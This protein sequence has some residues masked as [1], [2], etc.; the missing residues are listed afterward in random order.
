MYR[1]L[2]TIHR[3]CTRA[4]AMRSLASTSH[5]RLAHAA[6]STRDPWLARAHQP[7]LSRVSLLAT[8]RRSMFIQTKDVPNHNS[9]MFYPNVTVLETGTRDF[10]SGSE[11][12]GS[13]LARR[14]FRI[15]GVSS[16]FFGPDYVTVVKDE[17]SDWAVLKPHIFSCLMDFFASGQPVITD[18]V[19]TPSDTEIF[20]EDDEVVAMI[21]ELLDTRI[22]P[23]VQEDGG[24][25]QYMGFENGIVKLRLQGSCTTCRSSEVTLKY[26]V[27][28][29]LQHYIPEVE[30]VEQV[31]DELDAVSQEELAKLE[32][33]LEEQDKNKE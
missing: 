12:H 32:A 24:D 15:D 14:L 23:A 11:A 31:I 29:M 26:G 17:D 5:L 19:V 10:P 27:E 30:G 16:V 8:P 9:L 3:V 28:N 21:K 4:L 22:R 13:P 2:R 20:D 18:D 25:L 7:F 1:S 33:R 6:T